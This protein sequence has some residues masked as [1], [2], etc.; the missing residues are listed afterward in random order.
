MDMVK[1]YR[2]ATLHQLQISL[3]RWLSPHKM[4]NWIL[5][6]LPCSNLDLLSPEGCIHPIHNFA[7]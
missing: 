5:V 3:W 1:A 7:T 2:L 6:L 4:V